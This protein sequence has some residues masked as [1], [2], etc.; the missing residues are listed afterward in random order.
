MVLTAP[1][2][3]V[4]DLSYHENKII[5]RLTIGL[6]LTR[7]SLALS[8]KQPILALFEESQVFD[9]GSITE[10]YYQSS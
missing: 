9:V 2:H 7:Q 4:F 10:H 6:T 3:T 8:Q 5:S 1:G